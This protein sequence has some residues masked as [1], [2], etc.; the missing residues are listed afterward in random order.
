MSYIIKWLAMTHSVGHGLAQQQRDGQQIQ[1]Y[2]PE[3]IIISTYNYIIV[4]NNC[5]HVLCTLLLKVATISSAIVS[6]LA[7]RTLYIS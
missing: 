2:N 1:S 7:L 5:I 4:V 6:A 3:E